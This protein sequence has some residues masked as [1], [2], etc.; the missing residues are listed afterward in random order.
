[1]AIRL[2]HGAKDPKFRSGR[3]ARMRRGLIASLWVL[4]LTGCTMWPEKKNP[5]WNQSTGAEHFSRLYWQA[6]KD[7]DWQ[8]LE[9]R[10][11]SNYTNTFA[12]AV[13]DKQTAIAEYKKITALEYSLG[14]FQTVHHGD[15]AVVTYTA[16][17][18]LT[19]DGSPQALRLR[20]MDV[21]QQHKS[22]WVM[23]AS[24]DTPVGNP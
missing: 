15:T 9:A 18:K 1:M 10:T 3:L 11:A 22:G 17:A 7:H 14:D 16:E 23:I 24:S 4:L 5:D 6:I 8:T 12:G 21:W 20:C 19:V 13:R 2:S